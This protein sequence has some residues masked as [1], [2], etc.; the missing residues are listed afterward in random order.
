MP[1][2]GLNLTAIKATQPDQVDP[3]A[4]VAGAG[5]PYK[6]ATDPTT[7]RVTTCRDKTDAVVPLQTCLNA[8]AF[9]ISFKYSTDRV[10]IK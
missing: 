10:I 4:P 6:F 2:T 3:A 1:G 5:G 9:S 7:K 8:A